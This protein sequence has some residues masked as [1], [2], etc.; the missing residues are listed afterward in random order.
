[1]TRVTDSAVAALH[2]LIVGSSDVVDTG[3]AALEAL[4]ITASVSVTQTVD[5]AQLRESDC[6]LTDDTDVVSTLSDACPV[7]YLDTAG[8]KSALEDA[9]AAGADEVLDGSTALSP[10]LLRHRLERTVQGWDNKAR[11]KQ[12]GNQPSDHRLETAPSPRVDRQHDLTEELE[13]LEALVEH[14]P[15]VLFALDPD[16]TFCLSEGR[17]LERI[18]LEPGAI[19][20]ESVFDVYAENSSIIT[21]AERALAGESVTSHRKVDGRVFETTYVPVTQNGSLER[22]IGVAIDVTEQV[23]YEQTLHALYDATQHLLTVE[24]VQAACEYI[25]DVAE[26][27]LELSGV[28]LY[29]FDE[30]ATELVPA[31]YTRELVTRVGSPPRLG[32]N[33]SITWETFIDGTTAVFGDVRDAEDVYDESTAFRSGL[34]VPLGDHGVLVALSSERN[35][36]DEQTVNLAEGFAAMAEAALDRITRTRRLHEREHELQRQNEYLEQRDRASRFR[37]GIQSLLLRA[38]SRDEIEQRIC[39]RTLDLEDCAFAWIGEPDPGGNQLLPRATAGRDRGY[40]DSVTVTAVD[41]EAGEPAGQAAHTREPIYV[42]N[43]ADLLREGAWRTE[44]LSR[45]VQSVYAVPLVYDEFLYGV[46]TLYGTRRNSFDEPTRD[47]LAELS[48]PIGYAIDA[49]RR[50]NAQVGELVTEIEL[51]I[52]DNSPLTRLAEAVDAPVEL[53]GVIPQRDGSTIIFVTVDAVVEADSAAFDVLEPL[54]AV[55]DVTVVATDEQ[56]TLQLLLLDRFF[57]SI[58]ESHGGVVRSYVAQPGE[59]AQVAI[60]VPQSVDV[61]ALFAALTR[62]GLSVSMVARRQYSTD[63]G[64]TRYRQ[65]THREPFLEQLTDRQREVVQT[66]YHS[67]FF[68]WPRTTTGEAIAAS[69]DISPPAFHNHIRTAER[70]LFTSLFEPDGLEE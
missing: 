27:I 33:S 3:S 20:G 54:E 17:A 5:P 65:P 10:P 4:E 2:V 18:G 38:D 32:P 25:V 67:G 55:V 40:L 57:T 52:E 59:H 46:L 66:A 45:N 8:S 30:R 48:E 26:D 44:A 6:V 29:R 35:L 12:R 13:H 70:K 49:V 62:Q 34:Y 11:Q 16:G 61:R 39:E 14:V 36:Y 1:M 22:V 47:V 24:S 7:L 19:V 64:K 53:E 15:L 50:K 23:Q 51:E 69:L 9:L 41:R 42:E 63:E 28:V 68:E 21:D 43:V 31:A 37:E 60:D 58:I 56:T